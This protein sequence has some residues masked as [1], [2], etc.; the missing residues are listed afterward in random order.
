M[1]DLGAAAPHLEVLSISPWDGIERKATIWGMFNLLRHCKKLQSL[2]MQ[3]NAVVVDDDTRSRGLPIS[4]IMRL[5]VGSSDVNNVIIV[6]ELAI[7]SSAAQSSRTV[8]GSRQLQL[9]ES[10]NKIRGQ[11][12]WGLQQSYRRVHGQLCLCN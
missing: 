4:S 2:Q 11:Y 9:W 3:F 1:D 7:Q 10:N 5:D 8:L 12:I 6:A